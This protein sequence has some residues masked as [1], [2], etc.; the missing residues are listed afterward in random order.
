[1]NT[2]APHFD[3]GSLPPAQPFYE[4]ELGE[5]RRPSRG[6]APPKSGCPFHDSKSKTSFRVNL[7]TGGFHCFG[8]GVKGGDVLAFVRLRYKLNFKE[9]AQKLNAW[10]TSASGA[11]PTRKKEH[12]K[13]IERRLADAVVD[14][15]PAPSRAGQS[16]TGPRRVA[17][18]TTALPADQCTPRSRST[19]R[20]TVAAIAIDACGFRSMSRFV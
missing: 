16:R 6:W 11:N 14:G 12:S 5:F 7:E 10:T 18:G 19:E 13:S 17:Q 20:R 15:P 4:R 1:M 8:C 2:H 3:R 9:G